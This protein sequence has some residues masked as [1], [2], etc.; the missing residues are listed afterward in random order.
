[1][2]DTRLRDRL[3]FEDEDFTY[4]RRYFW[5]YNT[6]GVLNEGIKAMISAVNETFDEDFWA[7]KHATLW[8]HPDPSSAAGH[9]YVIQLRGLRDD[10]ESA[11][12]KLEEMQSLNQ[13]TRHDIKDLR[14]QL[15]NGSSVKESRRSIE[16][17]DNIKA[18][19]IISMMFLPLIFVTVSSTSSLSDFW[20]SL[21]NFTIQSVFGIT[22]FDISP[23]DWRFPVTMVAICLP[24]FFFILVVQTNTGM[25]LLRAFID[26]VIRQPVN[27]LAERVGG[28]EQGRAVARHGTAATTSAEARNE[29]VSPRKAVFESHSR[30]NRSEGA[31]M[32]MGDIEEGEM[33]Y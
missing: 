18:L 17:A 14:D 28:V 1:M 31:R 27:I 9:H 25:K 30:R 23:N 10:L 3:L 20:H 21:S 8:P 16:Q 5:A 29:A 19:T 26:H 4:S 32:R 11:V 24:F 33:I 13:E 22:N 6:L 12:A 2:F 7:A 15:F